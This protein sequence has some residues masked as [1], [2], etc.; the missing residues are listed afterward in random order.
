MNFME[1]SRSSN[2]R[3]V[4]NIILGSIMPSVITMVWQTI[5]ASYFEEVDINTIGMFIL[6]YAVPVLIFCT[7]LSILFSLFFHPQQWKLKILIVIILV[8]SYWLLTSLLTTQFLA[9]MQMTTIP[10][11]IS[12]LFIFL[13]DLKWRRKNDPIQNSKI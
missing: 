1:G 9:L 2:N 7:I 5:K 11:L 10:I 13:L 4:S 3:D 12:F 6:V 8:I